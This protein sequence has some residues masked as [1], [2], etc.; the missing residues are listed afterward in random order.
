MFADDGICCEDVEAPG[1]D[2]R[3]DPLQLFLQVPQDGKC[4][5]SHENSVCFKCP[6]IGNTKSVQAN[7]K[8][9]HQAL[10]SK[11]PGDR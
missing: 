7:M 10:W 8:K 11:L 4:E 1:V 6:V 3:Q 5:E 9:R 2:V